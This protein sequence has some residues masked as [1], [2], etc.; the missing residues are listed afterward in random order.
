MKLNAHRSLLGAEKS[1]NRIS[2]LT[3]AITVPFE[4][5]GW[6]GGVFSPLSVP[7]AF[8]WLTRAVIPHGGDTLY[9]RASLPPSLH[10]H[11]PKSYMLRM[12]FR[13]PVDRHDIENLAFVV[14]IAPTKHVY[15]DFLIRFH[16]SII[17]RNYKKS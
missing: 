17:E 5:I 1:Y 16:L 10:M 15:S 4:D 9:L 3:F 14:F 13:D 6:C 7:F 2:K 11:L 8:N 12:M